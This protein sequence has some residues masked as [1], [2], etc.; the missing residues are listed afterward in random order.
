MQSIGDTDNTNINNYQRETSVF[1][2]TINDRESIPVPG[3]PYPSNVPSIS[4]QG[5]YD[6]SRLTIGDSGAC[7]KPSNEQDIDVVSYYGSMK[8][9]FVNQWGQIYSYQTID[10]GFQVALNNSSP[11]KATIFGGDTFISRFAFKNKS[12]FLF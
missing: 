10:T 9:I 11:A 4:S 8:K 6:K 2:D 5:V 1:I 3:L 7:G 12:A